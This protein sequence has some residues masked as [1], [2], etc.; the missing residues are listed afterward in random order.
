MDKADW[1][2]NVDQIVSLFKRCRLIVLDSEPDKN[3]NVKP[4]YHVVG[5][6]KLSQRQVRDASIATMRGAEIRGGLEA[7]GFFLTARVKPDLLLI[8]SEKIQHCLKTS[9]SVMVVQT[10]LFGGRWT[11]QK[12][13]KDLM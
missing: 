5:E 8:L 3:N 12:S 11:R 13:L 1:Q 4:H 9:M 10:I 6:C 2:L 7:K